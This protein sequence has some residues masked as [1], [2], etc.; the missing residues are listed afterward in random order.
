[1]ARCSVL[2]MVLGRDPI[3]G[4]AVET[5]T[6][7]VIE[8]FLRLIGKEH[9]LEKMREHGTIALS[10]EEAFELGVRKNAL[11]VGALLG[12]PRTDVHGSPTR[13]S[14]TAS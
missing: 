2:A 1:M 11:Q 4:E 9:E 12:D 14:E 8:Q 13:R 7:L 10:L 3:T 6:E 5:S